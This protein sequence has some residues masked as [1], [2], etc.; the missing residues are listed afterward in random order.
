[1]SF[2]GESWLLGSEEKEDKLAKASRSEKKKK[3]AFRPGTGSKDKI[4]GGL[5]P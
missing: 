4:G 3:N 5:N 2:G 1:M